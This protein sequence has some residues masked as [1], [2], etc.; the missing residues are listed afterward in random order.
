[1]TKPFCVLVVD[2]DEIQRLLNR[3]ALQLGFEVL[4]ATCGEQAI[5]LAKDHHPDIILMD[6]LMPDMDGYQTCQAIKGLES[7][8][9]V[10]VLFISTQPELEDRLAAYAAG[11]EDFISKPVQPAELRQ[12]VERLALHLGEHQAISQQASEAFGAAMS[13]MTAAGEQGQV[14]NAM[15]SY[16]GCKTLEQLARLVL[17][18]CS[19]FGLERC[20]LLKAVNGDIKLNQQGNISAI[21]SGA[22]DLLSEGDRIFSLGKQ[23]AF[24][25]GGLTLL[26]RNMPIQDV[27]LCGRLRDHLAMLAEGAEERRGAIVTESALLQLYNLALHNVENIDQNYKVLCTQTELILNNMLNDIELAFVALGLTNAQ[28]EQVSLL[29]RRATDEV[30][31]IYREG[32]GLEQ[33]V[34]QLQHALLDQQGVLPASP[35]G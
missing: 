34:S 31:R 10:P 28:E 7:M 17:E 25:Y 9:Q 8:E 35:H 5:Q 32:L 14:L 4:E 15:R 18:V 22:L 24:H 33:Q 16:F 2:D 6:I 26:I 23:T 3:E 20:I 19:Q 12:K 27:E 29:L 21:E 30:T 13:A 1:M 11:G